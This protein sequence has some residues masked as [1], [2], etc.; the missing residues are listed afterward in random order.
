V[1]RGGS[2]LVTVGVAEIHREPSHESE[3]TTQALLGERL[4]VLAVR[5]GGRWLRVLLPDGYRG[6]LRSWLA[7]PDVRGWPGSRVVE[8]DELL[9]WL[10]SAPRASAEPLADLVVGARLAAGGRAPAGWVGA[11]L[12]DGRAGFVPARHVL[13]GRARAPGAPRRPK[14]V[15]HLLD[16]ARR[17][18]GI[19][20]VWGGKSPKGLDCSGLTQLAHAL[21]DLPLPRDAKDQA[22][23]FARHTAR[24][25]DPLLVPPGGLLFFGANPRRA[26]HVGF[27]L[28]KGVFLHAQ[29]RVK[30]QSLDPSKPNYN[31][32]L[33]GI[34]LA[35]HPPHPGLLALDS[36]RG[37][38]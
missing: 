18:L 28:G 8:V 21:H 9:T 22:R 27:S 7:A 16:S 30:I 32:D 4:R 31:K 19:P 35:G 11:A 26:G 23:W 37:P 2:V 17:F 33:A 34:F 12:P 38:A 10:R 1:T 36:R 5:D 29:G 14:T 6:W 13:G 20:Y 3:I 25:K 15:R 24:L